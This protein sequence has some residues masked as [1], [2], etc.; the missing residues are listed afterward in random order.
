MDIAT[1][2]GLLGAFAVVIV[3]IL[4][5]GPLGLFVD[6]PSLFIVFGGT[7]M[8]VLTKFNLSQ[9]LGAFGVAANAF[10][11]KLDKP[12]DLIPQVVEMATV[13]RKEGVLALENIEVTNPFLQ[14][15]MSM[16]I[17][18]SSAEEM[19]QL[20][21]KD[22]KEISDRHRWG[23]MVFSAGADVA[24]A[25][26]MIGTLVGL[27]QMLANMEDPKT[28]GPSMAVALLTTLYGAVLAN[29]VLMPVADKLTLRRS[30]EVKLNSICLDGVLAIQE[31]QHPRVLES[32]LKLYITP[33]QRNLEKKSD[34]KQAEAQPQTA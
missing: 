18:G 4:L 12:E 16:L 27:V 20:L 28:I 34:D 8:V 22:L 26:G 17:D 2:G 14:S 1:L 25:M 33:K 24:P 29:M 15:G 9:F 10:K 23:A 19:R 6:A 21:S 7:L 3:A 30:E 32:L 31:G 13:A 5:G 11:S